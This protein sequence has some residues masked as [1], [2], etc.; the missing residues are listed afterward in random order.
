MSDIYTYLLGQI[1]DSEAAFCRFITANDVG[2]RSHQSG[3]FV[4]KS[5][6][7][8]LFNPELIMERKNYHKRIRIFWQ[9]S[10]ETESKAHYYGAKKNE[11]RI[12]CLGLGF[13]LLAEK[14][15][16]SL[17]VMCKISSGS[18]TAVI[19]NS[20]DD[21]DDFYSQ[22]NIASGRKSY[23]IKGLNATPKDRLR[24]KLQEVVETTSDFPS[25]RQMSDLARDLYNEAFRVDNRSIIENPDKYLLKWIDT[26]YELFRSFEEKFYRPVY[27]NAFP[28]C[29]ALIDFSKVI[30]NRRKSRAGK[31]LEHHLAN[32]F[33]RTQIRFSEQKITNDYSRPDF[34]FPGIIEYDNKVFPR[35]GLTFLGA[36]TTCKDRWRQVLNE[37][38]QISHKY[39]FT[40]QKGISAN[41]I[42][43]MTRANLSLVIPS[44][45]IGFFAK[46]VRDN[47]ISLS[48]F[49]GIIYEKQK[50]YIEDSQ[51]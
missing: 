50:R 36:K 29:Q 45:N 37:A 17:L 27:S 35:E 41:Q 26:E 43:E 44:D 40:L 47:L 3:F 48:Q 51:T 5:V 12:T 24:R 10:F 20:D 16:G 2:L 49:V 18:F 30:Q 7:P 46:E 15:V 33:E 19:L 13:K 34:L 28:S 14:G 9:N 32:I 4:S 23:V 22:Y 25:T 38:K 6:A 1:N 21:I 42:H 11:L 39:L 31:S 8:I